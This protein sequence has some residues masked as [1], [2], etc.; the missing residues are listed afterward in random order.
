MRR[1]MR[2]PEKDSVFSSATLNVKDRTAI[3]VH[4]LTRVA[5]NAKNSALTVIVFRP[6][7]GTTTYR[8]SIAVDPRLSSPKPSQRRQRQPSPSIRRVRV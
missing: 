2:Q 5:L 6:R 7:S 4:G 1:T 8:G 3:R